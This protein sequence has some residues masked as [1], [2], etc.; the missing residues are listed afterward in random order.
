MKLLLLLLLLVQPRAVKLKSAQG[1]M[2]LVLDRFGGRPRTVADVYQGVH[3]IARTRSRTHCCAST[4][5]RIAVARTMQPS[6][7]MKCSS[8]FES[9]P[10]PDAV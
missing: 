9:R 10:M 8:V 2:R 3:C 7:P 4:I 5:R 1:P 6:V